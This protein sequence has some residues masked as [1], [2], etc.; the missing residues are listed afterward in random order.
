MQVLS[1][2]DLLKIIE[3]KFWITFK[4]TIKAC[5]NKVWCT[6]NWIQVKFKFYVQARLFTCNLLRY[7]DKQTAK[8]K[9]NANDQS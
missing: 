4:L 2:S 3:K 5:I 7:F 1:S 6:Q 9:S 8:N